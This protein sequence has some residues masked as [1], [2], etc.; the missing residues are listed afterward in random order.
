MSSPSLSDL[1]VFVA[2]ARSRSFRGA[3]ALRNASA[4]ALSES[5]RRLEAQLGVRLLN[6]TTRSVTPTEAGERL[7]ERLRPALVE[8]EGALDVV[9]GFRESPRG[10]LRLNVPTVVAMEVLPPIAS[11]FLGGHPGITLEV[12]ANDSFIDI[13]A[14]GFDAGVRYEERIERDMIAV[15]IGPRVQRYIAAAAPSYVARYGAPV[16][17]RD[18]TRHACIR[19]RFA[20][21]ASP[22]WEFERA[23]EVIRV[24]PEGPLVGSTVQLEVTAAVAGLGIVCTFEEFLRPALERGALE[25]VLAD[26]EQSFSGP[27]L[28]YPSRNMPA[29]LR[30]FVDFIKKRDGG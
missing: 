15:P 17:P 14:A 29:P 3:A 16:H 22:D 25:R 2:V 23:G 26:W 21:G 11:R 13:V 27:F 7:L 24:K 19:H 28:Y 4:S 18:L 1:D 8:I 6:R 10:T 30:A 12:A 20:S 9:N 5:V